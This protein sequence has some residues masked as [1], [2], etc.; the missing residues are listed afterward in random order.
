MV[1]LSWLETFDIN[2]KHTQKPLTYQLIINNETSKEFKVNIVL[3]PNSES[4][5]T[6][7]LIKCLYSPPQNIDEFKYLLEVESSS[8]DSIYICIFRSD[9]HLRAILDEVNVNNKRIHVIELAWIPS[10]IDT[11]KELINFNDLIINQTSSQNELF[12]GL[13][14]LLEF[15]LNLI[16]PSLIPKYKYVQAADYDL[17][18]FTHNKSMY[19]Y[20][21]EI[22]SVDNIVDQETSSLYLNQYWALRNSQSRKIFE[23]LQGFDSFTYPAL[24]NAIYFDILVNNEKEMAYLKEMR[25]YVGRLRDSDM[26]RNVVIKFRVSFMYGQTLHNTNASMVVKLCAPGLFFANGKLVIINSTHL[27]HYRDVFEF[28][29]L[30]GDALMHKI[31]YNKSL[32][33]KSFVKWCDIYQVYGANRE[34]QEKLSLNFTTTKNQVNELEKECKNDV[35][36]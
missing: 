34:E 19:D 21:Q 17:I 5:L 13:D 16:Y 7:K 18:L 29:W 23:N 3:P 11:N 30:K 33:I 32:S 14:P 4:K 1:D 20:I 9:I 26:F 24:L 25:E 36:I 35:E 6:A 12:K 15:L 31:D 2:N 8:F 10:P 27:M 28:K 22:L